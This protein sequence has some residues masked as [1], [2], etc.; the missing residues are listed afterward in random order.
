MG[1]IRGGLETFFLGTHQPNWLRTTDEPLFISR[2]RLEKMNPAT[3][4]AAL[5]S[6]DHFARLCG[7]LEVVS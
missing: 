5:I 3:L 2:R 6:Y 7:S 4:T 1:L